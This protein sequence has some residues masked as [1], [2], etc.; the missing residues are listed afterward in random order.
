[1]GPGG[2]L[3]LERRTA[4]LRIPLMARVRRSNPTVSPPEKLCGSSRALPGPA[5]MRLVDGAWGTRRWRRRGSVLVLL[6]VRV[7]VRLQPSACARPRSIPILPIFRGARV[8]RTL[9]RPRSPRSARGVPVL[10][11]MRRTC[12]SRRDRIRS[13]LAMRCV[14]I[15]SCTAAPARTAFVCLRPSRSDAG[16]HVCRL[17]RTGVARYAGV[18]AV[19]PRQAW[20]LSRSSAASRSSQSALRAQLSRPRPGSQRLALRWQV[21]G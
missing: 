11:Q 4:L 17:S 21:L 18:R 7:S 16:R 20:R 14:A 13:L 12:R 6:D 10:A 2:E 3:T 9:A 19:A 5:L 1:M 8:W 15:R